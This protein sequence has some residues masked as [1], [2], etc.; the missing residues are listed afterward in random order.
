[1]TAIL[2][3]AS[4]SHLEAGASAGIVNVDSLWIRDGA[5]NTL[6]TVRTHV[7]SFAAA[8]MVN[9]DG[10][11]QQYLFVLEVRD[12][13]GITALT[14]L[15]KGELGPREFTDMD[16][17]LSSLSPGDYT[18]R[19]FAMDY[20]QSPSWFSPISSTHFSVVS[21]DLPGV[22][23]P[24]YKSPDLEKDDGVWKRVIEAKKKH[25]SVPF[26]VTINPAS[27]PGSKENARMQAAI[28]ELKLAGV[29]YILGYVPTGYAKEVQGR[30]MSDLKGMINKYRQW[31]PDV[32]GIMLDQIA[33]S[34]K[35]LE[36]YEELAAYARSS[37]MTFVRGNA[38]MTADEE[39][40]AIFDNIGIYEG[41]R[42]PNASQL[43]RNTYYP[44]YSPNKFSLTFKDI[45]ALD[46]EYLDDIRKYI[47]L[48]YVTDDVENERDRNPYNRLPQ[49]FEELI[50]QLQRR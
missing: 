35:N 9:G 38:G 3:S 8:R 12:S 13:K 31:Y 42:P 17:S 41:K 26:L 21:V 47:G 33:P 23:I 5:G 15:E 2:G 22:Y 50:A 16:V 32:S 34:K 10:R 7:D 20:S 39:Y 44:K 4:F 30:N 24:L 36:F 28:S 48:I 49:Y 29:E 40:L 25:A 45:A 6:E 27:G 1:L 43:E 18:L 14:F 37:G 19:S 46:L 11:T